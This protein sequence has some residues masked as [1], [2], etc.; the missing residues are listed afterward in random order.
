MAVNVVLMRMRKKKRMEEVPLENRAGLETEAEAPEQ[1]RG[2]PDPCLVGLID[3]VTLQ[4]AVAQLAPGYRIIFTLHDVEGYKHEE[5]AEI[6][7]CSPGNSKSQLN[8]ARMKL[9]WILRPRRVM[10]GNNRSHRKR[11]L[12]Q[13]FGCVTN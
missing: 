10:P 3:R 7:G 4:A 8:R 5:I 1:D 9:R 12:V 2:T 11:F 6:L 13:K